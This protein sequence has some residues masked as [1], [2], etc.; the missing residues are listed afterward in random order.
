MGLGDFKIAPRAMFLKLN[1]HVTWGILIRG[2]WASVKMQTLLYY[3]LGLGWGLRF[4]I[5]N[6]LPGDAGATPPGTTLW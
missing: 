4:C 2:I 6:E 3:L 5:S 1:A